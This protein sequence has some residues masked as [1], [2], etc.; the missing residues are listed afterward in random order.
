MQRAWPFISKSC[1]LA[2]CREYSC[3]AKR[4]QRSSSSLLESTGWMG[5]T[6][7][8]GGA[9]RGGLGYGVPVTLWLKSPHLTEETEFSLQHLTRHFQPG[10][11][12]HSGQ[13]ASQALCS[14]TALC[15]STGRTTW[16]DS[17]AC[18]LQ[19]TGL[20]GCWHLENGAGGREQWSV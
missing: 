11:V 10:R 5:L 9:Q 12:A 16:L 20:R 1:S 15:F 7:P 18:S 3:S 6:E 13:T 8:Q 19:A 2:C 4:S 17:W 14:L